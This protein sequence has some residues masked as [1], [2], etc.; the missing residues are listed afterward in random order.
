MKLFFALIAFV[1]FCIH[2]DAQVIPAIPYDIVNS[3]YAEH[4]MGVAPFLNG[5]IHPSTLDHYKKNHIR[6]ACE[7]TNLTDCPVFKKLV[8]LGIDVCGDKVFSYVEI[9]K[10]YPG[11]YG[12][13]RGDMSYVSR[14]E[15]ITSDHFF[16]NFTVVNFVGSWRTYEVK[17]RRGNDVI[18]KGYTV[19]FTEFTQYFPDFDLTLETQSIAV[20]IGHRRLCAVNNVLMGTGTYGLTPEE[21]F[22][23]GTSGGVPYG[24]IQINELGDWSADVLVSAID[25][26]DIGIGAN[27]WWTE[28]TQHSVTPYNAT[29]D[30]NIFTILYLTDPVLNRPILAAPQHTFRRDNI[31]I[32]P[33]KK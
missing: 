1:A 27:Y 33:S 20:P 4:G 28:K 17:F 14:I 3:S 24:I 25:G 8:K 29:S 16:Y 13:S 31:P 11:I 19:F 6:V 9:F 30:S 26:V 21:P 5:M 22:G 7:G 23:I 10:Q 32:P 12:E 2:V 15:S 18:P